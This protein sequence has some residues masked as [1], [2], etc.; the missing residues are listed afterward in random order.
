M[1]NYRDWQVVQRFALATLYFSTG[2]DNWFQNDG[3]LL[4]EVEEY[5][6]YSGP[7]PSRN[8]PI[9]DF[10]PILDTLLAVGEES[11]E[12]IRLWLGG[13][14]LRGTLR[15]EVFLLTSLRTID[16]SLNILVGTLSSRSGKL[17]RLEHILTGTIPIQLTNNRDLILLAL[18]DNE[19]SNNLTGTVPSEIW[20]LVESSPLFRFDVAINSIQGTVPSSL[21]MLDPSSVVFSC[22]DS[23]CG[24]E[25]PCS[26]G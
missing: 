20:S 3:W 5:E 11:E 16:L 19:C 12:C 10:Q 7:P 14:G 25:C 21:C 22:P 6:W 4:Y 8:A 1:T 13:N 2:G 9:E 15:E 18:R 23:L 24:C 26:A 17:Q